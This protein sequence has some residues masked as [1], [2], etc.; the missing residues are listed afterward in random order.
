MTRRYLNGTK[1]AK[2]PMATPETIPARPNLGEKE[3]YA[4]NY[5]Q[6][7]KNWAKSVNDEPVVRL[8]NAGNQIGQSEK[9][10]G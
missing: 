1:C 3:N 10:R 2:A 6:I 7:V 5:P 4:E 9:N 8:D